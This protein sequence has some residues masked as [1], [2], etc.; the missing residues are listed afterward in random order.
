MSTNGL[1]S[2]EQAIKARVP[3]SELSDYA[4]KLNAL[5]AGQ[6]LFTMEFDHYEKAPDRLQKEVASEWKPTAEVD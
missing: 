5:T 3:L 4:N 2:G 1:A 6:G